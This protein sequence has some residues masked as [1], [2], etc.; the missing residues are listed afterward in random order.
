MNGIAPE[1]NG[2]TLDDGPGAV[3]YTHKEPLVTDEYEVIE[4]RPL[5][6]SPFCLPP[7]GLPSCLP[8][9]L[10]S[11]PPPFPILPC[12]ALPALPV[13]PSSRLTSHPSRHSLPHHGVG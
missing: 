7:S 9:A 12:P 11:C 10:S 4:A 1:Q 3:S 5:T 6:R 8:F 13:F 2:A